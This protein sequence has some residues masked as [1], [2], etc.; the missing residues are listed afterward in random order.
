MG[1]IPQQLVPLGLLFVAGIAAL[2]AARHFLVPETFGEYGHYRAA[3]V[4]D[5]R[6]LPAIYAGYTVCADCH[7][8]KLEEVHGGRHRGLSC[9]VCHDAALAHAEDPG[10]MMPGIPRGRE[11]CPVCH[12]YNAARPSGFP[13]I[14]TSLH[15]PGKSC[16]GCHSAH[17]PVT[18]DTPAECSACHREIVNQKS[19]SHHASLKCS[20]CHQVPPGHFNEPRTVRAVKPSVNALC[21]G[22]HDREADSPA[23]IPRVDIVSHAGR[24]KCWDC[25]YPHFP[26]GRL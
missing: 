5:V 20:T 14:I 19:V 8:D 2:A 9:E 23:E 12:S 1:R 10:A 24:Y 11:F 15:N 13:Q 18:P 17:Q 7:D 21:A 4:D 22:C 16:M 3:A 6:A 25:H 26:E